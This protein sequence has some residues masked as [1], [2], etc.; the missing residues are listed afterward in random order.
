M[1]CTPALAVLTAGLSGP[2]VRPDVVLSG[3][4]LGLNLGVAVLYSGT[5][6]AALT[7][8]NLGLPAVAV[9]LQG[10]GPGVG[11]EAAASLERRLDGLGR[12]MP[13]PSWHR[14]LSVRLPFT[15]RPSRGGPGVRR[16]S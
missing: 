12:R 2:L 9:S 1:D 15:C 13:P 6:G 3:V 7:A 16:R 10:S 11:D 8:L 14:A 5:V 4:D